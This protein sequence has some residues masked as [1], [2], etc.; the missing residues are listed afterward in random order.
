MQSETKL[1]CPIGTINCPFAAMFSS[2]ILLLVGAKALYK[3]TY[4]KILALVLHAF[5]ERI[6]QASTFVYLASPITL[7]EVLVN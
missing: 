5:K 4:G 3:P 7:T 2:S 1:Y 6:G